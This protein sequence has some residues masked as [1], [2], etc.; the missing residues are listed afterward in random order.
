MTLPRTLL[1]A[2]FLL[3]PA[4]V[5][6]AELWGYVDEQGVAHFATQRLDE[7][8]S[9]FFR[10]KTALDAPATPP[11]NEA[12]VHSRVYQYVT[13]SPN[14]VRFSPL[15]A[16][17]STSFGVDPDL[18]K[19]VVAA[20]SAFNPDAVSDK[21]ALGLMQVMPDTGTRYGVVS[22]KKRTLAQ[23]LIDPT[24]N[25]A[26][27]ARYLRDLLAMF[28]GDVDLALAAYNAGEQSARRYRP[29]LP[30]FPET[31]EYVKLVREF[32]ELYR[33]PRPAPA[34]RPAISLKPRMPR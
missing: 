6:H 22:D 9:L 33:P 28:D 12:F 5:A 32:Y 25:V 3:A 18:V 30:P 19:A 26:V 24:I 17:K 11:A 16:A 8:Y 14:V 13:Q 31:Q 7:R 4:T 21:G 29:L 15:I 10:G 34:A 2:C 23:K 20:E 1:L 27:G